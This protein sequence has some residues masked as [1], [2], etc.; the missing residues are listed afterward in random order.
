VG[1]RPLACW[2]CGFEFHRRGE[3][4]HGCLS[5]SNVVFCQ[6]EVSATA[7]H[8]SGGVLPTVVCPSIILTPQYRGSLGPL[9]GGGAV[10]S[11]EK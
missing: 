2:D 9:G 10:A 5:V 3:G 7:E 4:G 8:S 11:R 6:V 1:L